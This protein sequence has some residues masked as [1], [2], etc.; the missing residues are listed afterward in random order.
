MFEK[1]DEIE[2]KYESLCHQLQDP[3]IT[4]NQDKFRQLMK[5]QSELK[6]IVKNFRR[7]KQLRQLIETNRNLLTE[8]DDEELKVLAK[9]ELNEAELSVLEVEKPMP[10]YMLNKCM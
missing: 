2:K 7:Y 8:E 6:K 3:K 9:E 1:L 10:W 5:E 4:E